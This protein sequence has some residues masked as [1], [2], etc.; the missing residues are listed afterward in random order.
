MLGRSPEDIVSD[1][2]RLDWSPA[3]VRALVTR[4]AD[5]LRRF[6]ESPESRRQLLVQARGQWLV[7]CL[8]ALAG[9]ALTAITLLA[10]LAGALPYYV[11]SIGLVLGGLALAARGWGR[12]RYYRRLSILPERSD[13]KEEG[14]GSEGSGRRGD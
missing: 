11:V 7:G 2:V 12:W 8:L 14:T 13:S 3:I 9:I 1:L 5:D 10:A 6:H 4:V